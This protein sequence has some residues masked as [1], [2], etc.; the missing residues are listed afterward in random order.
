MRYLVISILLFFQSFANATV[1][2]GVLYYK[3][4]KNIKIA[5]GKISYKTGFYDVVLEGGGKGKY[6]KS[7][8]IGVTVPK[9]ESLLA[10]E[11]ESSESIIKNLSSL[12][13]EDEIKE[14]GWGYYATFV[15]AF[16][17]LNQNLP[18]K[19]K[20]TIKNMDSSLVKRSRKKAK[21]DSQFL[22]FINL[23]ADLLK[24]KLKE[25]NEKLNKI[26]AEDKIEDNLFNYLTYIKAKLL[27]KEGK[28]SYA[29]IS[30]LKVV[31]L[32]KDVTIYKVS[33]LRQVIHLYKKN[34]DDRYKDF[35]KYLK[36]KIL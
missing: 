17:L 18:D 3:K 13:L 21:I 24:G 4:G 32:E 2:K 9:P 33:A 27:E 28:F 5:K 1:D 30:Y 8:I 14:F 22:S 29:I 20:K 6:S 12:L 31:F 7:Q 23:H 15:Y 19:A 35:E 10:L 26:F 34:L 36:E 25:V 11:K 16:A